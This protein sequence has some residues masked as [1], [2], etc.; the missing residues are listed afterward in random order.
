M[1]MCVK[2]YSITQ[3]FIECLLLSWSSWLLSW[4]SYV[5]ERQTAPSP[6]SP[7]EHQLFDVFHVYIKHGIPQR[8]HILHNNN[9]K[10]WAYVL[11][12]YEKLIIKLLNP[13]QKGNT[14]IYK[15]S[16]SIIHSHHSYTQ[17]YITCI[18][19]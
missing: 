16:K 18:I 7:H 9:N 10:S 12:T 11:I 8:I 13:I 4:V 5:M 6:W 3:E 14:F 1:H 19:K 15:C 2:S 17:L